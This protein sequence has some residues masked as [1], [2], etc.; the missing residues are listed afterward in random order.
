MLVEVETG[1]SPTGKE[2]LDAVWAAVTEFYGE[3]GASQ[4]GLSLV[5]YNNEK[6]KGVLR[7]WLGALQQVRASIASI[8]FLSGKDAAV[9]VLA[10]SGTLKA[11]RER[12]KRGER[13]GITRH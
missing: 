4:T 13:A 9:H 2:L 6:M 8:T 1:A 7:V 12:N 3:V 5:D 10:I 11:L